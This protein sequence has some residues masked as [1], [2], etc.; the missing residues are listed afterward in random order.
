MKFLGVDVGTGKPRAVLIDAGA[1]IG[2]SATIERAFC[3]AVNRLGG[4]RRAING[5]AS[6]EA[7]RQV[8]KDENVRAGEIG[9]IGLSRQMHGAVLVNEPDEVLRPAIIWCD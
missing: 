2:A 1:A 7:I 3:F 5:G 9:A 6:S 8:L 4:T